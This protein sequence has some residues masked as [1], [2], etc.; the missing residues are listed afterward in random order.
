MNFR[1]ATRQSES[2][3]VAPKSVVLV[4][5]PLGVSSASLRVQK[6]NK[7]WRL[8]EKPRKGMRLKLGCSRDSFEPS[9]RM[10]SQQSRESQR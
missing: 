10:A 9:C 2:T 1:R 3:L 5:E 4:V 8:S 7:Q 6:V